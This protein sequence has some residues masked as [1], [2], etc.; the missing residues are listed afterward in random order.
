M[1]M[2]RELDTVVLS[3]DFPEQ[4]L[5]RGDIGAVV[6]CYKAGNGFEVEFIT[7]QG[8]TVA[9]MTLND[10]D[11]RPMQSEEILHVRQLKAVPA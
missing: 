7:G 4:G 8:E 2:I 10:N 6:H 1:K 5:N 9:V 11:A 3:R